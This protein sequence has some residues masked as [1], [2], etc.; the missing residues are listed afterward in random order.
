MKILELTNYSAGI[1]GVWQRAKQESIEL[2]KKGYEVKIF[3]SNLEK[4]T[5]KIIK[6]K[7]N[8][9][10][11]AI[12]RFISHVPGK[13]NLFFLPG[14]ESFMFFNFI[15][16][17]LKYKPD[18]IIAHV[19]RHPH[20]V[21]AI[22]ISKKLKK[23]GRD[24]KIF[25]VTHA[26]F[27]EGDV[28]RSF[29]GH[30]SRWFY[31]VFFGKRLLNK[32]SKIFTITKWENSYL[33]KLGVKDEKIVYVPNGIPEELF[34]IKLKQPKNK[35]KQILF[36]GR[37]APIKDLETLMKSIKIISE[38]NEK[39]IL[40]LVGPEEEEYAL[41]IKKLI[42]DLNLKNVNFLGPIYDLKEKIDLI[43]KSDLFVLPSK[44]EG[45]PQSL[46]EAMA[47]E[48][49]VISST[50]DGG[51]ELVK[52]KETGYLFEVGNEQQLADKISEAL[53]NSEQNKNIRKNARKFVKQFN[54]KKLVEKI[55]KV[56]QKE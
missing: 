49:I 4:G 14:G 22:K 13:K 50:N 9:G 36:L 43:D 3:S 28:T 29:F 40:N 8:L 48:K 21:S 5:N 44:R 53:E 35:I 38:K 52:D 31:D 18:I 15:K 11:I 16:E 20:T 26:P 12:K 25:L 37:I 1:C 6:L 23:L 19:Y 55:E 47:R 46:I 2:S 39:V 24:C 17:A 30:I 34:K 56:L 51:K 27:I 45:M 10:N 41:K 7:D 32:Y 54:W 33:K 42:S